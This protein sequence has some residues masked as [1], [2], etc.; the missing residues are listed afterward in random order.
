MCYKI[1]QC[2]NPKLQSVKKITVE[3]AIWGIS[4]FY[5]H[6]LSKQ[7]RETTRKTCVRLCYR[8]PTFGRGRGEFLNIAFKTPILF[9]HWLSKIQKKQTKDEVL[10]MLFQGTTIWFNELNYI[11]LHAIINI[12]T[13]SNAK[14]IFLSNYYLTHVRKGLLKAYHDRFCSLF[15]LLSIYFSYLNLLNH[16]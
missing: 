8:L 5:P 2:F 4:C 13:E 3:T 6:S 12:M 9:C 14:T 11:T 16:G 10:I 1:S 15:K 7:C